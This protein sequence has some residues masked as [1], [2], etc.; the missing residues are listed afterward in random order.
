MPEGGQVP[1]KPCLPVQQTGSSAGIHL[2]SIANS[3]YQFSLRLTATSAHS[4]ST[5]TQATIF[6]FLQFLWTLSREVS[7]KIS[8]QPPKRIKPAYSLSQDP[9]CNRTIRTLCSSGCSSEYCT[10]R[11]GRLA[12]V[13][14]QTIKQSDQGSYHRNSRVHLV[15]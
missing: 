3:S 10:H 11:Q 9:S 14:I 6:T 4:R 7:I 8:R 13:R 5:S 2:I 1:G 15:H 12:V